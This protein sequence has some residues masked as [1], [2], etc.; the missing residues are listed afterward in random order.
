MSGRQVQE[1]LEP[2]SQALPRGTVEV[3]PVGGRWRVRYRSCSGHVLRRTF[4]SVDEAN[5]QFWA[6]VKDL[7]LEARTRI[8]RD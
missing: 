6:W 5:I 2:G 1:A 3:V 7:K 8:D 4:S